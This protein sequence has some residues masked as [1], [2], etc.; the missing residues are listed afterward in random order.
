MFVLN[1]NY[2]RGLSVCRFK[3]THENGF[4]LGG[5]LFNFKTKFVINRTSCGSWGPK[6]DWNWDS[7]EI[8]VSVFVGWNKHKCK[9]TCQTVVVLENNV[10]QFTL[11]HRVLIVFQLAHT[12]INN[13]DKLF[14]PLR[15]VYQFSYRY[16]RFFFFLTFFFFLSVKQ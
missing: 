14:K 16:A 12:I 3:V 2:F 10:I 1:F 4:S 13:F 7:C 6:C 8:H 11:I 15:R 9:I 5:V